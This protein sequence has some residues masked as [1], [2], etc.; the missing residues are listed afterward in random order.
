MLLAISTVE[1]QGSFGWTRSKSSCNE[2]EEV[3]RC[4]RNAYFPPPLPLSPRIGISSWREG[5]KRAPSVDEERREGSSRMAQRSARNRPPGS[6]T[7]SQTSL[8]PAKP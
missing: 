4:A 2:L 7:K 3:A 1:E 5:E 6:P 8:L